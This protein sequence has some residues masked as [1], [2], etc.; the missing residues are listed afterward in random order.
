MALNNYFDFAD[1]DFRYFK[2]NYDD[3]FI[4]NS[5]GALAQSVC[6]KYMKHIISEYYNPDNP[7]DFNRMNSMLRTHSLT[8]LINF[9]RNKMGIEFSDICESEM[10][11]I[12]GFYFSTRYP[13]DDSIELDKRGLEHCMLAIQ[14]CREETIDICAK[15]NKQNI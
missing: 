5:M 7:A 15:Q 2:H 4:A 10:R 14:S 11:M 13:G 12:D 6:E 1:D 3:G 9:L 8:N